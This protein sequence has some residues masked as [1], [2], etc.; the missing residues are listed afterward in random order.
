MAKNKVFSFLFFFIVTNFTAYSSFAEEPHRWRMKWQNAHTIFFINDHF[1]NEFQII[2]D[3]ENEGAKIQIN[4]NGRGPRPNSLL[5]ILFKNNNYVVTASKNG[6]INT[7]CFECA[8]SF[9][10]IFLSIKNERD[11]KDFIVSLS[12]GRMATF[13]TQG[14]DTLMSGLVCATGYYG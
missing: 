6:T 11:Y 13:S 2:C 8:N 5:S 1:Q 4:I 14:A 10:R 7:D 12:D 3:S 9:G